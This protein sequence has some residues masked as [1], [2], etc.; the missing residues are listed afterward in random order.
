MTT[1]AV[2]TTIEIAGVDC[3]VLAP[4]DPQGCVVWLPESEPISPQQRPQAVAAAVAHHLVVVAPRVSYCWWAGRRTHP[5]GSAESAAD[6]VRHELR[7]WLAEQM[8]IASPAIALVGIE[9]GGQGALRLS[10]WFPNDFPIAAAVRPAIDYHRLLE[11]EPRHSLARITLRE[12]YGDSETARQDT[13]TLH[14]HPLN[15]PRNQWFACPPGDRWWDGCDRLRM[16]LVSLGVMHTCDLDSPPGS[17]SDYDNAT[18]ARAI[19][20]AAERIAT[21][22]RRV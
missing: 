20:Y 13:A 17:T 18:L 12:L 2:W 7:R 3:E 19:D 1:P 6:W 11:D 8:T 15:W 16:K 22:R 5:L 14:I 9:S 4:C 21:E 10:Y